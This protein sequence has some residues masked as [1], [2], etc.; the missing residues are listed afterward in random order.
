MSGRV[1]LTAVLLVVSITALF[2]FLTSDDRS[3]HVVFATWGTPNEVQSFQRLIDYFNATRRPRYRVKLA[4]A[5]QSSYTEHL[6]VQAASKS[7]PDVIHMDRKDLPLFVHRNMLEDLTPFIDSD[8]TFDLGRFLPELVPDGRFNGRFYAVPHNFSTLVL[9]YNRDHFDAEGIR[10]PDS[11]WTWD[12]LLTASQRLTRRD[13]SGTIRR[14]GCFVQII[15]PTLISQ[16]GGSVLNASLDSCIVASPAA[17]GAVQFNI[18]LSEK[19]HVTWNILA[20]NLLWDDMFVGGRVS[21]VCNGR[22]AARLYMRSMES[23]SVDVAPLPRGRYRRGAAVNHMMAISAESEKK[24]DAWEFVKFLVSETGQRMINEDGANIPALRSIVYSD[25][26]LHHH[27]TPTMDNRVF[28]DELRYAITWPYDQ[29]P[30]LSQLTLLSEMDLAMR[31]IL[32]RQASTMQSLKTMQRNINTI[33]DNQRRTPEPKPFVGGVLFTI[34]SGLAG[35]ALIITW[36]RRMRK[37]H[38]G[39]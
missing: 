17:A 27:T 32:L 5:E 26:F 31:R 39:T 12:S 23:G 11:T 9:Y 16:N 21:M 8:T 14:Y 37:H 29:G 19:Y 1:L 25:E 7:L 30:F 15:V 6:L 18:D 3:R 35:L 13:A 4:H 28:L 10:Y 38:H 34:T 20:Q 24:S 22:W 36:K 33:I 2:V